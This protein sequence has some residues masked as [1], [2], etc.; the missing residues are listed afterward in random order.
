MGTAVI[1]AEFEDMIALDP[2]NAVRNLLAGIE[3]RG[4]QEVAR[5]VLSQGSAEEDV[6]DK[7]VGF[8]RPVF[9]GQLDPEVIDQGRGK[10]RNQLPDKYL[11]A[12]SLDAVRRESA[13]RGRVENGFAGRRRIRRIVPALTQ[14]G[15]DTVIG[16]DIPIQTAKRGIGVIGLS[17]RG[18]E[19][20]DKVERF[21]R[22]VGWD[23]RS[24]NDREHY[25]SR[26]CKLL[27]LIRAEEEQGIFKDRA[28]ERTAELVL[29]RG[30]GRIDAEKHRA[31]EPAAPG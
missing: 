3:L 12:I 25:E 8:A 31:S 26:G 5:A 20:A 7:G 4:R 23:Y 10:V 27:L 14:A 28:A 24:R 1:A 17:K 19:A 11:I 6:R 22:T 21:K 18:F 13:G 29:G 2:V 15:I 9:A 30:Q 16:I